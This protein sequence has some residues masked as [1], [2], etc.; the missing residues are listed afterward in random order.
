MSLR[1]SWSWRA[2]GIES[3]NCLLVTYF[4]LPRYC[5]LYPVDLLGWMGLFLL[6]SFR[7][8]FLGR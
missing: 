2:K 6:D 5:A 1:L 3:A 7:R 8:L 4:L